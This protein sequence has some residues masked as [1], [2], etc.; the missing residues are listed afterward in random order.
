M[1]RTTRRDVRRQ[2][3]D[4]DEDRGDGDIHHGS[5]GATPYNNDRTDRLAASDARTPAPAPATTSASADLGRPFFASPTVPSLGTV[6]T[7][8]PRPS[9]ASVF[10]DSA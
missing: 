7:G 10:E 6:V 1:R 8:L 5:V 2:T 9:M 3:S 4:G